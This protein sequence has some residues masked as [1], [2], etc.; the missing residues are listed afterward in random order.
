MLL[1]AVTL[2]CITTTTFC[3]VA[4]ILVA[5]NAMSAENPKPQPKLLIRNQ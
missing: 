2:F 4:A 3:V 5:L 1:A